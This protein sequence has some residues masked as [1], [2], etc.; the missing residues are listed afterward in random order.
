MTERIPA[1]VF[2]PGEFLRDELDARGWTQAD[3]AAI[4]RR[5]PQV[6]NEIITGRKAITPETAHGLAAALGTSADFWMNLESAYRLAK[7]RKDTD[8][9]A[10]RARLYSLAPVNEM[11]RRGWIK[12]TEEPEALEQELKAFFEVQSLD[13]TPNL[14]AAA[15]KSTSYVETTPA[16]RAWM[17]RA[18]RLAFA[19]HAP[20]FRSSVFK[21]EVASLRSFIASEHDLRRVPRFL[22]EL[23]VRFVVVEHLPKTRIDGATLWL[24]DQSPV[25]AMSLRHD[26]IDYFWFTLAHE[27]MHVLHEDG[28]SLDNDLVGDTRQPTEGKPEHEQRADREAADFLV[29]T[30]EIESFILRVRPLYYKKKIIQFANRIRVHPGIIVGQLQRREEIKYSHNR[31]M[32]VKTRAAVIEASVSDGWG[33]SPDLADQHQERKAE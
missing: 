6:V 11:A 14:C 24:D 18:K 26:R 28:W 2:P 10:R 32:L 12:E 15:R 4:L 13:E 8:D 21:R 30:H 33:V 23:G 20:Q 31:E 16:Q 5:P 1:E 19:V 7:T 3:L 22:A 17:H 27:I 29:P 25:I 9:V